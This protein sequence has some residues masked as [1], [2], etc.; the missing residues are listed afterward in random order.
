MADQRGDT[1]FTT[2][3][4][5][6]F[7]PGL[8]FEEAGPVG[9]PRIGPL[10]RVQRAIKVTQRKSMAHLVKFVEPFSRRSLIYSSTMQPLRQTMNLDAV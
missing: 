5:T 2:T 3:G 4:R 7:S 10:I 1:D 6:I 8:A 9:T